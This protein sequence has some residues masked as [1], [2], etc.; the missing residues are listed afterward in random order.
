[1]CNDAYE[2]LVYNN[3]ILRANKTNV[4]KISRV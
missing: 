2:F 3:S 1:M 4:I